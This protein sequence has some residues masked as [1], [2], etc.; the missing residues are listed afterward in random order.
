MLNNY[1]F[2][3]QL[4]A[5]GA[6]GGGRVKINTQIWALLTY[7]VFRIFISQYF[8]YCVGT[9]KMKSINSHPLKFFG[10][11]NPTIQRELLLAIFL[12]GL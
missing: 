3:I 10:F 6:G 7:I 12:I 5:D 2:S 4:Q 8:I 11:C 1:Y 9:Y